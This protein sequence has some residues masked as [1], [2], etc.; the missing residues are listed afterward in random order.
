MA[1]KLMRPKHETTKEELLNE[2]NKPWPNNTINKR[3]TYNWP[4]A[5]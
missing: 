5:T 1:Q 4:K 2:S 3:T